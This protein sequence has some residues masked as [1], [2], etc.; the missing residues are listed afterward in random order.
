MQTESNIKPLERFKIENIRNGHCTVFFFT[1]ITEEQ[2]NQD[3]EDEKVTYVYDMY[4]IKT[5]YRT[6]LQEDI[7]ANYDEWLNLA[8]QEE[9]DQLASEVRAKRDKLLEETDKEMCIDRIGLEIPDDINATNLLS[10]VK[11]IFKTLKN[12]IS[13]DTAKYRQELRD[14]TKQ[15]GFP[16]NVEWP[17]KDKEV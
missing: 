2:R 17:T 11:S 10:T 5:F 12:S 1:N 16:Y 9:Y 8:K 6:N 7:E 13:N 14:L 15:E 3:G 4:T